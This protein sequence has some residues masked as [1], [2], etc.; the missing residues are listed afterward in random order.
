MGI[1]A[2][3]DVGTQSTKLVCYDPEQK[4]VVAKASASYA[5]V[6]KDDGTRE[7]EAS[8]FTDAVKSCFSQIPWEIRKRVTAIG[9]SGQ[10]HGFVPLDANGEVIAPV[11]LWCDTSTAKECAQLT[12]KLGGPKAVFD[13]IGNQ[14]LP[15]YTAGKIFAM[16]LHQPNLFR[17]LA[18]ILLPHDYVNY[19]LTG[20]YVME[21]GD[22]SGTALFDIS[23][24]AW[25][26]QVLQ[27]IDP[28]A[29][30][31]ALL[32]PLV[33]SSQVIGN[34]TP[35]A[36]LQLGL[37]EGVVV[38][39]GGGDNMMAA[40]G[41]G[42]VSQGVMTVSMGTSGTLFGYSGKPIADPS[43]CLAGFCSSSG[44]WLPLLCTMNCTVATEE[45][46]SLFDLDVVTLD[47]M[48][49]TEP[50]GARGV[51]MLPYFNGERTP[52]YPNGKAVLAGFTLDTMKKSV[53]ARAALE[54]AVYSLRYGMDAFVALGFTPTS[55]VL[56]GGGANSPIWRQMVSDVFSLPVTVPVIGESAAFGA[57][58]QALWASGKEG[59]D[60]AAIVARHVRMD[61]RK[62][63][64]P[65]REAKA[66]YDEAYHRFL[67]YS[68][69]LAPLFS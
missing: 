24:R 63:C 64:V 50:I 5:L 31:D 47:G 4:A 26:T 16:K 65:E 9:V 14:I 48:A 22:A 60:L 57:A 61:T 35:K 34:L 36:A 13:L 28:E 56:T 6:S 45:V 52:N 33:P 39:A 62:A 32:P 12:E 49:A 59:G 23:R 17:R 29:N 25:S 15:G 68:D 8:W 53:I 3:L 1:T 30:W 20:R 27:A 42:C 43:G 55:I 54:S 69:T 44:G 11:K 41:T 51:T 66:A 58:I 37:D 10:Q 38:S 21:P 2:G 67:R 7:Q 18:H 19:C 40:I 46:R